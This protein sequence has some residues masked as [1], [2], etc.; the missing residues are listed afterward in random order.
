[1]KNLHFRDEDYATLA[2]LHLTVSAILKARQK[3][4]YKYGISN[5]QAAILSLIQ[6]IGDKATPAEL[7]R[8]LFRAP[9]SVSNLVS[10]MEKKGLVKKVNDLDRK[11]LVRVAITEKGQ[12][13]YDESGKMKSVNRIMSALSEEERQQLW[14]CLNKLW[15]GALEEQGIHWK[16]PF[17]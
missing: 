14:S 3:E 2:L 4:L 5:M 8:W 1:M 6:V 13:V 12:Q 9:H 16:I 11:N 10:R 7:S 15:D 17:P